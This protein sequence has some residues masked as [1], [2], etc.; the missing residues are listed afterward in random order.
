MADEI[1]KQKQKQQEPITV[2]KPEEQLNVSVGDQQQTRQ[3][4]QTETVQTQVTVEATQIMRSEKFE[5]TDNVDAAN[6]P[7]EFT[8]EQEREWYD[9]KQADSV[10][11]LERQAENVANS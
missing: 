7:M 4:Q 8:A 2:N 10:T 11:K 9:R 5:N 1:F 3:V 6:P